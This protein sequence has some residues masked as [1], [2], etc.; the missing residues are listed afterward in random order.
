MIE[1]DGFLALGFDGRLSP[2]SGSSYATARITALAACLLAARPASSVAM[3]RAQIF[4]L[5]RPPGAAG[6]VAQG[7]IDDPV[8]RNRGAC[9]A[10]SPI[11]G[12]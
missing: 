7:L 11:S 2:V 5:A 12:V 8:D 10:G 1:A 3:L 9:F 6:Y 4:A